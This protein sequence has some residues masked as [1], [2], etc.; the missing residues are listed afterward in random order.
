MKVSIFGVGYVGAVSGACLARQ[1]AS[2]TAV[3]I[4]QAKVDMINAGLAPI[5]EEGIAD[6]M[7]EVVDAGR[8]KATRDGRSAIMKTDVSFVSV[9]TPSEANGSLSTRAIEIVTKEIGAAIRDKR[10]DHTV[11]YR[12]TLLPGTMRDL[13]IPLLAETSGRNVGDGLEICYNPEF[14]REGTSIRDF[15]APPFTIIGSETEKGFETLEKLYEGIDAPIFR[16]PIAIAESVKY[17]CNAFHA[18]KISFANEM[19]ALLKSEGV[20]A[21]EALRIFCED[22]TLNISKAYLRPGFAFGGSCLPKDLRALAHLSK[23]NDVEIPMLLNVLAS[24]ERHLDRAFRMI[25]SCP[26]RKAALLGLAFKPGTDDLRESPLVALAERMIGRGYDIKI[27]DPFVEEARLTG[28]NKEFIAKEIP[29]LGALLE[30]DPAAAM[31][32]AE[33]VILGHA[34]ES[35]IGRI[36]TAAP[37]AHLIDLKGVD[38]LRAAFG[39]RYCGM[40]W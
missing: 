40:C 7:R 11:V 12:S 22:T 14:L 20:D 4:S 30:S 31:A 33:I 10:G 1:G 25:A 37:N 17:L 39:E 9:G 15:D 19:G 23:R 6:L 21:R 36:A 24:N 32:G 13:V 35:A 2:V 28:A 27:Y 29:H 8:M 3:D 18:L 38:E 16:T 34:P 26:G 5:I